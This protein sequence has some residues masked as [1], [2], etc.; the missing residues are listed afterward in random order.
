MNIFT[1]IIIFLTFQWLP[2]AIL[3]SEIFQPN[4][5]YQ[6][7]LSDNYADIDGD[8]TAI[9]LHVTN[10]NYGVNMLQL[11]ENT[12]LFYE[13]LPKDI[14]FNQDKLFRNVFLRFFLYDLQDNKISVEKTVMQ[15]TDNAY[16]KIQLC[17][18]QIVICY[19]NG[20]KTMDT[21][22]QNISDFT[23][24]PDILMLNNNENRLRFGY[25]FDDNMQKIV[26]SSSIDG[27]CI[28]DLSTNQNK[29]LLAPDN[30]IFYSQPLGGFEL[31]PDNAFFMPDNKSIGFYLPSLWGNDLGD[32]ATLSLE[33]GELWKIDYGDS[34]SYVSYQPIN[35]Q[36][37]EYDIVCLNHENGYTYAS[38]S[39][40]NKTVGN[41]RRLL[42]APSY[43]DQN[44]VIYNNS[45]L[46]FWQEDTQELLLTNIASGE[47]RKVLKNNNLNLYCKIIGITED[48]RIVFVCQEGY[49]KTDKRP[50]DYLLGITK[51]E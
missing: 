11:D 20:Y 35:E 38:A 44:S 30:Q 14:R 42:N 43:F 32:F 41:W 29:Q 15:I 4:N 33:T 13:V 2:Q 27:I 1:I 50:F 36:N 21:A 12:L 49:S 3:P 8:F 34:S 48:N 39:W 46:A 47:Q 31:L 24:L 17:N 45:Y 23:P 6:Q 37:K 25:S 22:L 28:Y 40:Q 19:S 16:Y 10:P 9:P 26:W 5:N 51:N 18:N 7:I